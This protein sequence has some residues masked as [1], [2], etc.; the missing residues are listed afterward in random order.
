MTD[1][2]VPAIEK[3]DHEEFNLF[4]LVILRLLRQKVEALETS[5]RQMISQME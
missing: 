3:K 5:H 1:A 4:Q 2:N